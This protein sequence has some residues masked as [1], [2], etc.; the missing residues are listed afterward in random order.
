MWDPCEICQTG[1][2]LVIHLK[3][4]KRAITPGQYAVL[5][6]NDECL[7]SAKIINTGITQFSFYYFKTNIQNNINI[8]L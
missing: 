7:G 3:N 4:A 6:K 8:S 2:G 1:N 5:A